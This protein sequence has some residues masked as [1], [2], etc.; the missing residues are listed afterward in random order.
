MNDELRKVIA[1]TQARYK[2]DPT[3]A[4]F[5]FR[6]ESALQSGLQSH[7]SMRDH[8]LTVDEP[9]DLGGQDTGP[10]PVELIL[11]A[12]GSCQEITYRA[13]AT[14]LGIPLDDVSVTLDGD[15]DLRGF[16]GVD[17][18]VRPGYGAIKGTV[19]LTSTAPEADLEMLRGAVNAHCPVLDIL[20]KGV[21]VDLQLDLRQPVTAAA[22]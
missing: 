18:S 19:H 20:T 13:Y 5:T 2:A 9:K 7:V 4:Q 8:K 14:A 16:F 11:G 22:E 17:D 6:S 15:I 3:E 1:D 12:L 21:P 10:N